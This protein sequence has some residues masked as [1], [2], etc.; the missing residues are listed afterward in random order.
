MVKSVNTNLP[1]IP[2]WKHKVQ[3]PT[4][5]HQLNEPLEGRSQRYTCYQAL[6]HIK[7][8][9]AYA[10]MLHYKQAYLPFWYI[11]GDKTQ[12]HYSADE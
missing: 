3:L 7:C 11:I 4:D 9:Q 12:Y 2:K 1:E 6:P 8:G 10:S 5:N